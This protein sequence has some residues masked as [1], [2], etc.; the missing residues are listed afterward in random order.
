MF[1]EAVSDLDFFVEYESSCMTW[2]QCA[3]GSSE[4]SSNSLVQL[5]FRC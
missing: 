3:F 5:N 2:R 4:E 1:L